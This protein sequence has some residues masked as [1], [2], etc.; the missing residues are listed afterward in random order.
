MRTEAWARFIGYVAHSRAKPEFDAEERDHRFEIARALREILETLREDPRSLAERLEA[1]FRGTYNRP[2][3]EL[4]L[5]HQNDWLK[6]WAA[7]D[8]ASLTRALAGFQNLDDDP[9]SRFAHFAQSADEAQAAGTIEPD[10][11]MVLAFGSLF[12]FAVQPESLPVIRRSLFRRLERVLGRQ[13][14]PAASIIEQ[15]ERHLRFA[16]ELQADMEEGRIPIRDML[17]VQSLIWIAAMDRELWEPEPSQDDR[18]TSVTDRSIA[19]L[20]SHPANVIEEISPR[21]L[22]NKGVQ[23]RSYLALGRLALDSIRLSILAAWPHRREVHT[24]LDLPSGYGRV[25]RHLKA[26]YP[27]ARLTACDIDRDAVDFCA[28]KFGATPVYGEEDPGD[29]QLESQFDLIWCGS[30]LT[31][32][33]T[34]LWEAFLDLFESAL[35]PS[36]VLVVTTHGRSIA[37]LMR[38]GR[39]MPSEEK[40][41]AILK[42]YAETGFGYAEYDISEEERRA[43]SQPASYGI[44]L[45]QPSWV[46][47]L[48]ERRPGLQLVTYMENRWGGQDVI[49][50]VRVG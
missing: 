44:S 25:L 42:S 50:C 33:D 17:D 38:G 2:H 22:P 1:V 31:H 26:E 14:E 9:V 4:T 20:E 23:R 37:E 8:E 48:L 39:V 49:G 46:C 36:G 18:A 10:P 28:T 47:G 43:L 45:A 15:Y 7:T 3:Y 40:R 35:A 27:A 16:R 5:R 29:L 13:P 32:V 21:D 41:E 11:G 30:L 6:G 19:L 12:N 34:P 24:I